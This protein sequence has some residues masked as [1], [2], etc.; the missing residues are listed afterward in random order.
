MKVYRETADASMYYRETSAADYIRFNSSAFPISFPRVVQLPVPLPQV[1]GI[2]PEAGTVRH[3][4]SDPST[5]LK[6]G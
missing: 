3:D 1:E 6:D 5:Q 2:E 4:L